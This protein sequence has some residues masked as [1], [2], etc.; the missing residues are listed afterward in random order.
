MRRLLAIAVAGLTAC[1]ALGGEYEESYVDITGTTNTATAVTGTISKVNGPIVQVH[2]ILG[3]ATNVD[4]DVVVDPSY[5]SED[6]L[7]LYSADD[8][9]AD[10]VLY[11][12]FDRTDATGAALTSDQPAPYVCTGDPINC[13]ISDWAQASKTARVKIVWEKD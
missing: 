10:T 5:S 2:V 7:T 1:A 8:V 9:T 12:V 3:T 13:I 4:V 6:S 11:P